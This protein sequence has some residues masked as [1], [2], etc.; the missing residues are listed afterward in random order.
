M[1]QG[2]LGA[3]DRGEPDTVPVLMEQSVTTVTGGRRFFLKCS[4]TGTQLYLQER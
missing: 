2:M 4:I 3:G 1:H